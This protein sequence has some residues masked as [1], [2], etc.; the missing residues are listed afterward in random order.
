MGG[1]NGQ[2]GYY[3]EIARAFLARRGG[4]F[5]LSPRDQALIAAWEERRIPLRVVLEGIGRAFDGLRS[6]GRGTKAVGLGFCGREV[7]AAFA[8]H[9][10]RAAGRREPAASSPASGKIE[11]ARR[12]IGK[13]LE[14][15]PSGDPGLRRLLETALEA[16][17]AR[18][19]DAATLERIEDE[20]EE[21]LWR[22]TTALGPAGPKGAGRDESLRRRVIKEARAL[23]RI[24]HVAL[25]YY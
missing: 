3:R 4:P 1:D 17:A 25:H 13:A 14:N 8:Q 5:F 24:P 7:E 21:A 9:R 19:P 20:I 22:G 6:R 12:E 16:L 11:R 18:E 15:L 2:S 23:R 10:D